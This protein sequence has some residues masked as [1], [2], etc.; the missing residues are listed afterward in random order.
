MT[1]TPLSFS[2]L[3]G[4]PGRKRIGAP[5]G[6]ELFDNKS[7]THQN[8]KGLIDLQRVES[9]EQSIGSNGGIPNSKP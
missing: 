9:A 1:M 4:D 5:A 8:K 7:R 2:Q 3:P 6:I